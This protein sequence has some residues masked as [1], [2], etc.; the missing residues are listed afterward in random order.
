[1]FRSYFTATSGA[2]TDS[3]NLVVVSNNISNTGTSGF[4]RETPLS[5]TF[6]E[7]LVNRQLINDNE[8]IG[9]GYFTR[10]AVD[11]ETDYSAGDFNS[12]E[13]PLDFAINGDGYFQAQMPDGTVYLSRDGETKV[14]ADGYLELQR[15]GLLLDVNRDPIFI[16]DGEVEVD[17]RGN[18]YVSGTFSGQ[19]G[20]VR[21]TDTTQQEK[22]NEGF[23]DVDEANLEPAENI[24]L[25][26]K[27]LE[28][29]NVDMTTEM[30]R[31]IAMQRSF[32]SNTQVMKI[33][34]GLT[35]KTVNEIGR[36]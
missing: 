15:G 16:G 26:W 12:T 17:K 23:F 35:E 21:V 29:S 18:V 1:M 30:T 24:E 27:T 33:I 9:T 4:K 25:L 34:D 14:N 10:L 28:L 2:L 3:R 31:A 11:S 36:V 22:I 6:S 20:I 32:Q 13:N 19:I 8:Q 5:T 7:M